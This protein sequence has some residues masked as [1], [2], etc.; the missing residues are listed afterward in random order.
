MARKSRKQ[1]VT[2]PVINDS[3]IKAA[4]YIRL[5]VEDL[6]NKG[7]SIENQQMIINDYIDTHDGFVLVG[8]YIDNGASGLNF[9]RPQFSKMLED[10]ENGKIDCVI[11]KDLSRLGRSMIDTGFY[12]E[13]YFPLHNIRFISVTDNYDSEDKNNPQ[14]MM[15]PVLNMVNEMYAVDTGRKVHFANKQ[16]MEEGKFVG[17]RAPYGYQKAPNDCHK[18][19]IDPET[20]PVVKQIFEWAYEK[21][22]VSEIAKRLNQRA[23]LTPMMHYVKKHPDAG[24]YNVGRGIWYPQG[25]ARI[26]F[27]EIYV[28]NM[29]QGKSTCF[30]RKK[31]MVDDKSKWIVVENTHEAIVSKEMF[32]VVQEYRLEVAQKSKMNVSKP[33][34]ENI[35]VGKIFCGICGRNLYRQRFLG[36]H[37]AVYTYRCPT[38]YQGKQ[39]IEIHIREKQLINI[40]MTILNKHAKVMTGLSITKIQSKNRLS[41]QCK[42]INCKISDNIARLKILDKVIKSLYE[43]LSNGIISQDEYK[44]FGD[45]YTE[46]ANELKAENVALKE[47]ICNLEIE[48]SKCITA[49]EHLLEVV[50]KGSLTSQLVDA[51]IERIEVM[52]NDNV[53]I[54]FKFEDEFKKLKDCGVFENA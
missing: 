13:K 8:T 40:I 20:A 7:N 24:N 30:R 16:M 48:Y 36:A 46:E 33:Y 11:V 19:I 45:K 26:L 2:E 51:L 53:N 1:I 47:Q 10:I 5:S 29:V 41:E 34:T 22:P 15:M 44:E 21:I 9:E 43:N 54:M 4:Q 27:N 49:S 25:V 28:G 39:H 31:T 38:R 12:I 37:D 42:M 14:A 32:D 23:I 52:D 18:L 35:F 6:H 17:S 50:S 3:I